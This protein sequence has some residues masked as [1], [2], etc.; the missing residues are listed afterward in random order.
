M[1]EGQEWGA[2]A[3]LTTPLL[4]WIKFWAD[5]HEQENEDLDKDLRK[6][7]PEINPPPDLHVTNTRGAMPLQES[8]IVARA[9]PAKRAI[10]S[11]IIGRIHS[12]CKWLASLSCASL[13]AT[14]RPTRG[15]VIRRRAWKHPTRTG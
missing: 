14:R 13:V 5:S 2:I 8:F 3:R 1:D 12:V 6:R 11:V 7:R 10:D 9:L 4:A 15:S